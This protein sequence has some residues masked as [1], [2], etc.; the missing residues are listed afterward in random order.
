MLIV[1]KNVTECFSE[2]VRQ[3]AVNRMLNPDSLDPA[4]RDRMMVLSRGET[5][6]YGMVSN[7]QKNV[8]QGVGLCAFSSADNPLIASY[9]GG[10]MYNRQHFA[11]VITLR[12]YGGGDPVRYQGEW[13]YGVLVTFLRRLSLED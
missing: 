12:N 11:G 10:W 5:T 9:E 8:A 2:L 7:E 4:T 1:D 13:S 6:Y 3:C